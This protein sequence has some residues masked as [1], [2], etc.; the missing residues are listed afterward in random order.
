[1]M[2]DIL[3]A[4]VALG[5]DVALLLERCPELV[6]QAALIGPGDADGADGDDA[7]RLLVDADAEGGRQV[8]R[9]RA[10]AI[11]EL[12][13][14]RRHA[15]G[16]DDGLAAGGLVFD[17]DPTDLSRQNARQ[18]AGAR[19]WCRLSTAGSSLWLRLRRMSPTDRCCTPP[20]RTRAA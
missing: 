9:P 6:A 7:S 18:V 15:L 10:D 19:L 4:D 1:M 8:I 2:Q 5:D 12:L 13:R 16:A 14:L 11:E 17:R 3:A 20:R